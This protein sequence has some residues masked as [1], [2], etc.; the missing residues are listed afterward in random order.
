M[1]LEKLL[2]PLGAAKKVYDKIDDFFL[3]K[4]TKATSGLIKNNCVKYSVALG[5]NL[6]S[7]GVFFLNSKYLKLNNVGDSINLSLYET[8][9]V[10]TV[11]LGQMLTVA[12]DTIHSFFSLQDKAKDSISEEKTENFMNYGYKKISKALR[13]PNMLVGLTSLGIFGYGITTGNLS[14][15]QEISSLVAGICLTANAS[16]MYIKSRDNNL[17]DKQSTWEKI[18]EWAFTPFMEKATIPIDKGS[19]RYDTLKYQALTYCRM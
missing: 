10:T 11:I 15:V 3:E 6:L 4:Y 18:K 19:Q 5:I 8:I 9:G 14:R 7:L 17:L 1:T 16:S 2:T 13:V 12:Y